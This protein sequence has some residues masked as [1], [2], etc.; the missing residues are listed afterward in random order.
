MARSDKVDRQRALEPHDYDDGE[1]C[2]RAC[3]ARVGELHELA[4]EERLS[5]G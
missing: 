2:A 1:S 4:R 5:L 3:W